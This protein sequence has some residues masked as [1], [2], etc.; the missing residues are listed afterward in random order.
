M[1]NSSEGESEPTKLPSPPHCK[2]TTAH[3]KPPPLDF[4]SSDTEEEDTEVSE[5]VNRLK[6]RNT[7][8]FQSLKHLSQV[9]PKKDESKE[10]EK[11]RRENTPEVTGTESEDDE[12][13]PVVPPVVR[14]RRQGTSFGQNNSSKWFVPPDISISSIRKAARVRKGKGF[15]PRRLRSTEGEASLQP[16]R[17]ATSKPRVGFADTASDSDHTNVGGAQELE[18]NAS[19]S[20]DEIMQQAKRK[21]G[22]PKKTSFAKASVQPSSQEVGYTDAT[23]DNE[24]TNLVETKDYSSENEVLKI[25]RRGRPPKTASSTKAIVG[26]ADATRHVVSRELDP[27]AS[28]SETE[29]VKIKNRKTASSVGFADAMGHTNVA[30]AQQF[31]PNANEMQGAK[32]KRGRPKKTAPSATGSVRSPPQEVGFA[33]DSEHTDNE[34]T[35]LGREL[36]FNSSFS[37]NET[38]G[39]KRK[40]GRPKK[41]APSATGRVQ[42]PSQEGGF[43]SDSEHTNLAQELEFNASSSENEVLKTKKRGRPEKTASSSIHPPSQEVGYTDA[44]SDNEYTNLVAT[45]ELDPNAS[46][47]E[48]EVV[49]IIKRGRPPKIASSVGFADATRR[50]TN[51]SVS[52]E[53]E[54]SA[55]SSENE[56]VKMGRH[57]KIASSTKASVGFADATGHANVSVSDPNASSSENE[58]VKIKKRGRPPKIASSVGFAERANVSVSQEFELNASSS[59][60]EVQGA[61][62]K[63]GRPKKTAPSATGSVRSPPQEVGFASDSEHTNLG[64]ELEFNSSFSETEMQGA[65][66]KRGRPK[67]TAPSATGSVQP[68]SQEGGFASDSEH[69]NLAQELAFN[70]SSLVNEVLKTKRK[71]GR[72]KKRASF[73]VQPPSQEVGASSS[74]DESINVEVEPVDVYDFPSDN[75]VQ[76]EPYLDVVKTPGGRK[77]RRL[78]VARP[79]NPTPGMRRSKRARIPPVGPDEKVEYDNRRRSGMLTPRDGVKAI[80][81]SSKLSF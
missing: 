25:K 35:N 68:P 48:N 36:E 54:L 39:A 42:P 33:S 65:K 9:A 28:S 78:E 37:E 27:N 10:A 26:F 14:S 47:S 74:S 8:R 50:A 13:L 64:R 49:K 66:R 1:Q 63:R 77:F 43:A 2:A 11:K 41:T 53:F 46:S 81:H 76:N 4:L 15:S 3:K 72:P 21:R 56:V 69:T 20:E 62:R 57:P 18:L 16:H 55:S 24:Y 40:R 19:S 73:A 61:K 60:N 58:V 22:R 67:K 32:R 38:Q 80:Q 23:S 70:A 30:V 31:Q 79:T 7:S 45:Q 59:E 5:I 29:V 17:F 44:A 6:F 51:V 75:E 71:R 12:V 52:R 34:H